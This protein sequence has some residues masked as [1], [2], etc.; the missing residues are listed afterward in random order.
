MKLYD[1][2]CGPGKIFFPDLFLTSPYH[3]GA[4]GPLLFVTGFAIVYAGE[5]NITVGAGIQC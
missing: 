5:E 4:T 3:R 2:E 1:L